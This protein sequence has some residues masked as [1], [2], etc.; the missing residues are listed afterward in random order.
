MLSKSV[1]VEVTAKSRIKS[2]KNVVTAGVEPA[3]R[4]LLRKVFS[5]ALRASQQREAAETVTTVNAVTATSLSTLVSADRRVPPL[6]PKKTIA[7][8]SDFCH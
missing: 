3:I 1:T 4:T 6:L 2:E 5:T 7:H 8:G